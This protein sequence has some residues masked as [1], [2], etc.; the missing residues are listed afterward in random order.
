MFCYFKWLRDGQDEAA[1]RWLEMTD[2]IFELT[3]S[4]F[5]SLSLSLSLPLFISH[6]PVNALLKLTS[7][8]VKFNHFFLCLPLFLLATWYLARVIWQ[9]TCLENIFFFFKTRCTFRDQVYLYFLGVH[10]SL[11]SLL[12][13][14]LLSLCM[15]VLLWLE[16]ILLLRT[17]IISSLTQC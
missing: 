5:L 2:A 13:Y 15:N 14:S 6:R 11:V 17:F 8:L 1:T 10:T 4:C 7:G 9:G 16:L 12:V 3:T